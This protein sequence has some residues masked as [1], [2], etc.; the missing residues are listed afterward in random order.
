[1][2]TRE[3]FK[4]RME[5]IGNFFS[6]QETLNVLVSKLTDGYP[7]IVFGDSVVTELLNMI[8]ED[9]ERTDGN[10]LLDW[11]L[12]EKDNRVIYDG[13]FGE[14]EISVRSLDELYD[15]MVRCMEENRE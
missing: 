1:M 6:E 13:E 7:I 5:L 12:Y 8:A 3:L 10:D 4:K 11:W 9:F 15:Y 14:K 2:M